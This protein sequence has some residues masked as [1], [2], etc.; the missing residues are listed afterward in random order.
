MRVLQIIVFIA[1]SIL[2]SKENKGSLPCGRWVLQGAVQSK[3]TT[4][5]LLNMLKRYS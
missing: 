2:S 3:S 5:K 1:E 4:Y